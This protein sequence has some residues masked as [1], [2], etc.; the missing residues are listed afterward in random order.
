MNNGLS[1]VTLHK[2]C[3]LCG[4]ILFSIAHDKDWET[5]G[6]IANL[7]WGIVSQYHGSQT[8]QFTLDQFKQAFSKVFD[9]RLI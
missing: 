7:L 9:Y 6:H 8:H 4:G 2:P 5:A 3:V 1:N